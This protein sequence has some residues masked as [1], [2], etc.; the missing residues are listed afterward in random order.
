M[1]MSSPVYAGVTFDDVDDVLHHTGSETEFDPDAGGISVSFWFYGAYV[2]DYTTWVAKRNSWQ[3]SPYTGASLRKLVFY[4]GTHAC[5]TSAANSWIANEWQH[6]GVTYDYGGTDCTDMFSVYING[7]E[8]ATAAWFGADPGLVNN[9][10]TFNIGAWWD[11]TDGREVLG[12]TMSDVAVWIGTVITQAEFQQIY[13]S[14]IKRFPLQIKPSYLKGF[15]TLNDE[16]D[17]TS[18]D[19]DVFYDLSGN[20]NDLTGYDGVNDSGLTAKA[21]EVLSYP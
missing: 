19:T 6:I 9:A 2:A 10:A 4:D 14:R 1:L 18:A 3:F 11:G 15:W 5:Y 12:G 21:E 17:G 8:H 16:E 7:T 13:N 20:G